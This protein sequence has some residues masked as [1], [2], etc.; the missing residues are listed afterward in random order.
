MLYFWSK[1]LKKM[2]GVAIKKSVIASS[3]KIESGSQVI[4]TVMGRYSFCGYDCKLINCEIGSFC[5]IADRVSIGGAQHPIDW[6][7]TSPVFYEGRDSV[8]KKFSQ[9]PREKDSRTIIGNDVW[10]GEGAFI[11][12]GVVIG[13]G[14]VVGMGSV[15]TKN[16]GDYE[17]W[18][19]NPARLIRKRFSDEIANKL[20]DIKWWD[21][22]DEQIQML[23]ACIQNP[24]LFIE[25]IINR[26]EEL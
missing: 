5:S 15:V 2:R 14:A 8:K 6:V 10:I 17:I 4:N 22:S 19:G 26:E 21:M 12:G 16:I 3:S 7:S 18:G 13:N 25:E 9:F 20:I 11:K 1:I 23:S 24:S